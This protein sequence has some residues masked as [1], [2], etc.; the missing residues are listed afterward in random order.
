MQLRFFTIP[1]HGGS[2]IADELN[3]FLAGSRILSIDRHLVQDG[4]NSA[5]AVCVGFESAGQ[6]RP[7]STTG[8]A[9]KQGKVD[10]REVLNEAD[11]T[12]YARLRTLRKEIADQEGLPA[13]AL[14]TNEQMAEMV[15]HH[16]QRWSWYAK[17]DIRSYF[18]RIDHAILGE[19]LAR[20]FKDQPLL[21]LM[22][23]IID[24]HHAE[25]RKGFNPVEI[26]RH[27][28][29]DCRTNRQDSRFAQLC[30][31][32]GEGQGLSLMHPDC[33]DASKIRHPWSLGSGAPCRNDEENLVSTTSG[34][35]LPIGALTSQQ[36]ANYYGTTTRGTAVPRTV[37]TTSPTTRTTTLAF[38]APELTTRP[39]GLDLNRPPSTA[40]ACRRQNPKAPGVPV[41]KGRR[42]ANARR[43]A[44]HF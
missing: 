35:G 20:R 15:Q 26:N 28:G 8:G 3:R 6:G 40:S 22:A 44:A 32:K 19:L 36:F 23:R 39:D 11:F 43:R 4:V 9:G 38:V 31:P 42:P 37:T 25:P 14:F 2:D 27:S 29:M 24:A 18:A 21:A 34:K 16:L 13:Y 1:I 7:S 30:C 17:I 41:A 33:M 12:V 5:W 10:Y